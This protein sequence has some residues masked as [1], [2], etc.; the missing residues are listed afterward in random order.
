MSDGKNPFLLIARINI[1]P[2]CIEK[3][4]DIADEVDKKTEEEE[5]GMIM[6][7]FDSDPDNPLAFTWSEIYQ[8]SDALIVHFN[9]PYALEYVGKHQEL[10]E[11]FDL[12]I[13]GNLSTDAIAA[14]KALGLP[15]KHFKTT[16]VGF[17]RSANFR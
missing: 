5:S 17:S 3:Y 9:A 11:S 4:L 12:E 1:K 10:A 6:H 13:Y 14:V 8:N 7:N 2:D 15:C 16:R